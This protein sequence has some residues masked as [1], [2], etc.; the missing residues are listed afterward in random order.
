VDED[1]E[2][3]LLHHE[4][5]ASYPRRFSRPCKSAKYAKIFLEK[6][7]T[8]NLSRI[9]PNLKNMQNICEKKETANL[10]RITGQNHQAR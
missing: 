1:H 5:P 2:P 3:T 8:A 4:C 10:S 6:K 9:L 7:E